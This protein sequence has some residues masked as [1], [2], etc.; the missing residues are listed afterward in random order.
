MNAEQ[1]FSAGDLTAAA[2]AA[3]EDVKRQPA[4]LGPRYRLAE[5]L[6]LTGD[7]ERADKQLE[8]LL[9]Q[10]PPQAM[11]I[12]QFR[13]LLRGEQARREI[14]EQGRVPEFLTEPTP[15]IRA[16]LAAL[17]ALRAGDAGEAVR[18]ASLAEQGRSP[19]SGTAD[20]APFEDLR[21]L[22]DVLG[23]VLE[24]ITGDGDSAWIPLEHIA[25]I[26]FERPGRARDLL[27]R[28]TS[29]MLHD[30][31]PLA[32]FVPMQYAGTYKATKDVLKM[33]RAT[34]WD[35]SAGGIVRGIGQRMWLVGE[36]V[37]PV[38]ELKEIEFTPPDPGPDVAA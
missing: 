3:V 37:R 22:D 6:C 17:V 27:W 11:A 7:L 9:V 14:A 29:I 2:K 28:E 38:L 33:S 20:G 35:E 18:Q 10:F 23:P 4:E 8:T 24:A 13:N 26:K 19:L 31:R 32:V 25:A 30:G 36:D 12:S 34:E 21:D 1:L 16:S 15:A 5:F